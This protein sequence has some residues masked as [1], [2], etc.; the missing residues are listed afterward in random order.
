MDLYKTSTKLNPTY[1]LTDFFFFSHLFFICCHTIISY[2]RLCIFIS[3]P[4]G[5]DMHALFLS[6]GISGRPTEGFIGWLS[7]LGE[8]GEGGTWIF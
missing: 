4:A 5:L 8:V 2:P 6:G 3:N 1:K 7:G